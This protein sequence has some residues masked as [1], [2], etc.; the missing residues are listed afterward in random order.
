VGIVPNGAFSGVTRSG[1][2]GGL[3]KDT[4][5]NFVFL[6]EQQSFSAA[7]EK[8]F[9]IRYAGAPGLL[10]AEIR[11]AIRDVDGRVPVVSVRSMEEEFQEF[12]APIRI[13]AILIGLFAASA[14]LVAS[15]G[16]YAAIAFHTAGRTREFGIRTALGA[17]P[18]QVLQAVL[19]HGLVL[20]AASTAVG[21]IIALSVAG[22]ARDLLVGV[23]PRDKVTYAAVIALLAVVSLAA[24]Y[25][26]ARRASRIDPMAALRQD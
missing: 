25:L 13:P 23:D 19:H 12:I 15:I 11:A 24:C 6:A 18:W 17:T 16:L 9:H 7:G 22:S 8:T 5:P 10:I 3:G 26:P 20:T 4:R 1:A 21:V 2:F 14:L